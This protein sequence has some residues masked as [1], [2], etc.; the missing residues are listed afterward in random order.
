ML[1]KGHVMVGLASYAGA[2]T[3][4]SRVMLGLTNSYELLFIGALGAV[5]G[6]L[7]PDI[8]SKKSLLGRL[9]RPI[10]FLLNAFFKHRTITHCLLFCLLWLEVALVTD[11]IF[12]WGLALGVFMHVF[13]DSFSRRGVL[14][15][16]PLH[17]WKQGKKRH[18][19][20]KGYTV[21]GRFEMTVQFLCL[22]V[23]ILFIL[24]IPKS[25]L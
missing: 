10:N 22:L 2:F 7:L 18:W 20:I 19:I 3:A 16:Y 23:I 13:M 4:G 11:S 1:A 6:S 24:Y 14:W 8:D 25:Q 21:G 5:M 9:L 15:L 17:K 12:F